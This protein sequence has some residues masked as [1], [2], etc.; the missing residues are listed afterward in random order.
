MFILWS[1]S[2]GFKLNNPNV[3]TKHVQNSVW[4]CFSNNFCFYF[5]IIW[6]KT[7]FGEKPQ[8]N[9]QLLLNK[10]QKMTNKIFFL[11][12]YKMLT[13]YGFH[14]DFQFWTQKWLPWDLQMSQTPRYLFSGLASLWMDGF[15]VSL[16]QMIPHVYDRLLDGSGFEYLQVCALGTPYCLC[17]WLIDSS[18]PSTCLTRNMWNPIMRLIHKLHDNIHP[19]VCQ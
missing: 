1:F 12:R 3:S 19:T 5:L 15:W 9:G 16:S 10:V 7:N 11:I 2:P 13:I 18:K 14:I 6:S 8:K 17:H 4:K